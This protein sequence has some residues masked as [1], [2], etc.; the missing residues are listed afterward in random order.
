MGNVGFLL[1][2]SK[3]IQNPEYGIKNL[4]NIGETDL[5]LL[6]PIILKRYRTMPASK[7]PSIGEY[8]HH[9]EQTGSY[10]PVTDHPVHESDFVKYGN[11]A[12]KMAQ[13]QLPKVIAAVT[14]ICCFGLKEA[15]RV[16]AAKLLIDL[17]MHGKHGKENQDH[18]LE[19]DNSMPEGWKDILNAARPPVKAKIANGVRS[20]EVEEKV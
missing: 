2:Q 3:F 15:A 16:S 14:N 7:Q 6:L 4:E 1:I 19:H 18:F 9:H 17:V 20:K 10:T 12:A 8:I 5:Y 13:S 11:D